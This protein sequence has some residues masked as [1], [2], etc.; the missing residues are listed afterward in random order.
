M[1]CGD[2]R[3]LKYASDYSSNYTNY[4]MIQ[5]GIKYSSNSNSIDVLG[6]MNINGSINIG[7][8]FKLKDEVTGWEYK[9]SVSDGKLILTPISK[10]AKIDNNI[11]N[12]IE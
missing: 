4:S 2:Y 10:E 1:A 11:N 8:G 5:T 12:I 3:N 7:E 6:D 9:L